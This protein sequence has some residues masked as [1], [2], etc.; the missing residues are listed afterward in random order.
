MRE[1]S[2]RKMD[3]RQRILDAASAL[4]RQSG[5]DRVGVDA[6]MHEAGLTH[7]GFYAHFASKEALVAEVPAAALAR[8]AAKWERIS[9]DPD[10]A[11]ALARIV[12]PYLDPVHVGAVE[13]GCML[14]ALGPEVARRPE[15]RAGIT[16]ALRGM[17][18]ALARCRPHVPRDRAMA[19][20][21]CMVGAVMLARISDDPELAAGFLEAAKGEIVG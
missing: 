8:S 10:H 21:S 6:I 13:T 19:A 1:T 11:A 12:G 20:L 14:P 7:G 3:T 17:V 15:A 18:D 16:A 9:Q 4:F 5:I 2:Q